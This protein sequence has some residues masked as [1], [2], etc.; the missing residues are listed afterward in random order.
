MLKSKLVPKGLNYNITIQIGKSGFEIIKNIKQNE[1]W[2]FLGSALAS[3][4]NDGIVVISN[5]SRAT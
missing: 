4:R 3:F 1:I 2:T 5:Y